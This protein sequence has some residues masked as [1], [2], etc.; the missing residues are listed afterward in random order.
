MNG[1]EL[2]TREALILAGLD[3]IEKF[4][5]ENMSMR[6]IAAV[7]N[8]SCAAPYKHFANR[9]EYLLEIHR[10]INK[11]WHAVF[12]EA[13]KKSAPDMR[14]KIIEVS[15]AHAKFLA[16]HPNFR[17]LIMMN[18]ANLTPEQQRERNQISEMSRALIDR[19]CADVNMPKEVADRK[20][21]IVRSL[22]YGSAV[23][24]GRD[25]IADEAACET[26]RAAISRE[27]DIE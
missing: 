25:G 10:Y 21:F 3:D 27:F 14:S 6:R 8:V 22:I 7:C 1:G 15:V 5:V 13:V 19:Y 12:D 20:T 18:P 17:T 24:I 11:K 4:G 9:D 16:Q 2:D 23:M 26:L